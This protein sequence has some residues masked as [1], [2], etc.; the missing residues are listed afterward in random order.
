M[1]VKIHQ[2][3]PHYGILKLINTALCVLV[4]SLDDL[5]L[6]GSYGSLLNIKSG[7]ITTEEV[8]CLPIRYKSRTG[9]VIRQGPPIL[10]KAAVLMVAAFT[11]SHAILM[12]DRRLE[13]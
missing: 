13:E 11:K 8:K 2:I 9:A 5:E 7:I 12:M 3:Y 10:A 6:S 1:S 4:A